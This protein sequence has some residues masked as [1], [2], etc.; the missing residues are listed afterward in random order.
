[1]S[2][3]RLI[4]R[5]F[6]VEDYN[7]LFEYLSQKDVLKYEPD[8]P[9]KNVDECKELALERSQD[10]IF[11]AVCHKETEKMI[12]HLYFNQKEPYE[13]MTW[14]LGYIFNP[15]FYGKGFA[16]EACKRVLQYGFEELGAH[17]VVALCNPENVPSWKPVSYTHL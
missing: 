11:L 8:D 9:I 16:T 5:N 10:N 15:K 4:I 17:R 1:M 6:K 13:F 12:G 14:E 2:P 3:E 7:D